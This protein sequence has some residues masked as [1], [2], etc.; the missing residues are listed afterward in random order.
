MYSRPKGEAQDSVLG[1]TPVVYGFFKPPLLLLLL[2]VSFG[3]AGSAQTWVNIGPAPMP[4]LFTGR[5]TAVAVDPT[6]RNHWLAGLPSGG[7][8]ESHDAGIH[9]EPRTDDQP[10]LATGA[11]TFAPGNPKIVYAGTGECGF[12]RDAHAGL[13]LL[14]SSDGGTTW[15]L[16]RSPNL[17]RASVSGLRVHPT[18]PNILIVTTTR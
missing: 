3:P 2:W 11:I 6:D 8:W 16:I 1:K 10:T 17:V 9:W 4:L 14:K 5:I 12:G 7:I 15:T 18:D 13:G